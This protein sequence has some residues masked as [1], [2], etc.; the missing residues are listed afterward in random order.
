M[1][2]FKWIEAKNYDDMSAL[3]AALFIEQLKNKPTSVLGLA[4]GGTPEGLYS[5]LV[6]SY[7]EKAVSFEQATSFNLDEYIGISPNNK[8]SYHYYMDEQ[9]FNHVNMPRERIHVPKGD[10]TDTQASTA[11]YEAL[12]KEAGGIDIQLLGIGINGHIGFNEPG[13]AF[14]SKTQ[15]V[16]LTESTREANKIYFDRPEDVP[17]HAITMGIDTILQAKKVVLLISGSTKQEAFYRLRSGVMSEDF[18][19]SALHMHEDVTVIYTD[20]K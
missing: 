15:I 7:K 10:V 12:I 8:V 11:T 13:T 19:A 16:E 3:G 20:I 2:N 9:L 5:Q 18:P 1:S 14:T 4:T 6:Q 17:T